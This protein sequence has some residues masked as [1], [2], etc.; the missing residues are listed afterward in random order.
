VKTW[1]AE[2]LFFADLNA[3]FDNV[4]NNA[5]TLISPLTANLAAG[6]FSLTG[7]ALGSV[8]AASVSFTAGDVDTGLY[9][10]A[11][12]QLGI[13]TAGTARVF[14]NATGQVGIGTSSPTASSLLDLTSTTGALLVPRMTTTQRNALTAANGMLVYNSTTT[15]FNKYENGA[16]ATTGGGSTI[17]SGTNTVATSE[18]TGSTTYTDLA[19]SGP[20]V[21]LTVAASGIAMVIVSARIT[22]NTAATDFM[23]FGLTSGNTR[24][25]SDTTALVAV[26]STSTTGVR[27][28]SVTYLTGLTAG[29]TV[30]TA[31]YR[32]TAGT[33]TFLDRSITV[34]TW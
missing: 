34:L 29:S 32:V 11:A 14:I 10:P 16:W 27:A 26:Q 1:G 6:G 24:S 25:A 19:T 23:D 22:S 12:N 20:E 15:A 30:F 18:T 33:G 13:T 17:T 2:T 3:E 28:S 7:L 4:L 21:T 5:L 31:K 8:S 9:S